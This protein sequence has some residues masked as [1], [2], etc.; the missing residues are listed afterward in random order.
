MKQKKTIIPLLSIL[1]FA[2]VLTACGTTATSGLTPHLANSD[3][4]PAQVMSASNTTSKTSE[5][6]NIEQL[7]S[8][9]N[10]V[11]PTSNGNN[12]EN[13]V[14]QDTLPGGEC[15]D[16]L[17]FWEI[18]EYENWMKTELEINQ[19][20]ADSGDVSFYAKDANDNYICRAWTQAD[21]DLLYGQWQEQLSLMKQ[22]YH[23][24]KTITLPDGGL[25]SGAFDPETWN[26]KPSVALGSTIITMPDK[27]TVDLGHFDTSDE[28]GKAVSNY[29]KKQVEQGKLTQKQ[30]D[31]ILA[32]GAVE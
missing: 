29:L 3:V 23:F 18:S 6:G 5:H 25:L 11:T 1:A 21:V 10:T 30:A 2:T 28:A 20:L 15:S 31:A 19:K 7:I 32:N 9:S 24:T 16:P 17:E 13:D 8:A 12:K 26:A 14:V 22:G 4:P 27:S